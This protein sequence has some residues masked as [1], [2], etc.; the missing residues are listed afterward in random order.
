M[1][2]DQKRFDATIAAFDAANAE[3]PNREDGQPK[4]LLYAQRMSAM[5]LAAAGKLLS[6]QS[7]AG[8]IRCWVT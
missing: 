6:A 2:A 1:I 4:E 8:S 3:D 5:S 7:F